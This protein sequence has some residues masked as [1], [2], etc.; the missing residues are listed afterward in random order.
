[1]WIIEPTQY[2]KGDCDYTSPCKLLTSCSASMV[3]DE[4]EMKAIKKQLLALQN[5]HGFLDQYLYFIN[6]Q[7]SY[8]RLVLRHNLTNSRKEEM[9]DLIEEYSQEDIAAFNYAE[10]FLERDVPK[11]KE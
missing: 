4:S 11:E 10:I 8:D 2:L 7:Y 6:D 9:E 5:E 1:M 3:L